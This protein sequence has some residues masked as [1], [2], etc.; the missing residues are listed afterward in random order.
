MRRL[1]ATVAALAAATGLSAG[2]AAGGSTAKPQLRV[3][4]LQPFAVAGSGFRAGEHV[5]VTVRADGDVAA[6]TD[7]ADIRGRIGVRFRAMALGDCP[8]YVIAA[9]G[10]RGSRAGLRSVP[11]PCGA[12]L[13]L[14][15]DEGP[16]AGGPSRSRFVAG[17]GRFSVQA[18]KPCVVT[19]IRRC[20]WSMT[21]FG[22]VVVGSP[23]A[24][25]V[26]PVCGRTRL[27]RPK[28]VP[29]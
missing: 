20:F 19:Y 5:R 28:S 25:E 2:L 14:R 6:R 24:T 17:Y 1:T 22:T 21:R 15:N 7:A 9:R 18:P 8:T 11:R 27:A 26:Q 4:S 3:V 16:P 10:D 12:E 13:R 23:G 29:M